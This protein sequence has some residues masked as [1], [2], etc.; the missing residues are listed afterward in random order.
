MAHNRAMQK[1]K[2]LEYEGALA[3]LEVCSFGNPELDGFVLQEKGIIKQRK[4]DLEGALCDLT[5]ALGLLSKDECGSSVLYDCWKH[6]GYVKFL[7]GDYIS[8]EEHGDM[9]LKFQ[10]DYLDNDGYAIAF[11][12]RYGSLGNGLVEYMHFRLETSQAMREHEKLMYELHAEVLEKLKASDNQRALAG[13]DGVNLLLLRRH[14][15]QFFLQER[16]VL[17]RLAGNLGEALEDLTAAL[18][19]VE[20]DYEC[21]KHRGYVKYLLGDLDGARLDAERCLTIP[22]PELYS[23]AEEL[24]GKISVT[25]LEYSLK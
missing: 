18:I 15:R 1:I 3:E 6:I 10:L 13:F 8:A 4:G 21:L 16:G 25:Y 12:I 19:L 9:A 22:L 7:M 2:R 24:L 11:T 5:T 14:K 23:T 17:Q 20:N